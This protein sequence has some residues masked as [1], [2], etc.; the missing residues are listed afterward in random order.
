MSSTQAAS[1]RP[2]GKR[3]SFATCREPW[4]ELHYGAFVVWRDLA[5][6]FWGSESSEVRG[7]KDTYMWVVSQIHDTFGDLR[8]A[9]VEYALGAKIEI[10]GLDGRVEFDET[11]TVNANFKWIRDKLAKC[12]EHAEAQLCQLED[13]YSKTRDY[14]AT[15]QKA[16]EALAKTLLATGS[17]SED[18]VPPSDDDDERDDIANDLLRNVAFRRFHALV[19]SDVDRLAELCDEAFAKTYDYWER[20]PLELIEVVLLAKDTVS[21]TRITIQTLTPRL[22][23]VGR[24]CERYPGLPLQIKAKLI[25]S[26]ALGCGF[27]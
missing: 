2:W 24:L 4:K 8:T 17:C 19:R 21:D 9:C 11:E 27:R 23:Y 6:L 22:S 16:A 10:F 5:D 14:V 13:T 26:V 20:P 7:Q 12:D 25:R 1:T 18:L 15:D 3:K